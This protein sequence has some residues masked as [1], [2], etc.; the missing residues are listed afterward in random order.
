MNRKL[1]SSLLLLTVATGGVCTFTSCKDDGED[2]RSEVL[3]NSANLQKQIDSI[4]T[5]LNM[6]AYDNLNDWI[7]KTV[8]AYSGGNYSDFQNFVNAV[9]AVQGD[10]KTI[11]GYINDLNGDV[12]DLKTKQG[13]LEALL[14][15]LKEDVSGLQIALA[16]LEN[17]VDGIDEKITELQSWQMTVNSWMTS[18]ENWQSQVNDRLDD[19]AADVLTNT[20]AI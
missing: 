10:I 4:K 7:N 13:F 3:V 6:G 16:S 11:Y 15:E 18:I 5:W 9:V 1:L 20:L 8:A 2:F 14:N 17:R 12:N 19:I